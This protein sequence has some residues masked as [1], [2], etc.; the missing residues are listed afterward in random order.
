MTM[1][2]SYAM[3]KTGASYRQ[4]DYWITRG[5]VDLE[6]GTGKMGSGV[7][8]LFGKIDLLQITAMVILTETGVAVQTAAEFA[9]TIR[10]SKPVIISGEAEFLVGAIVNGRM[11]VGIQT[12]GGPTV[13]EDLPRIVLPLD[14]I[15]ARL[16][17]RLP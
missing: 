3:E 1:T 7:N 9:Q 8:K 6:S 10:L 2:V 15:Y 5:Y 14:S 17:G 4:I 16:E 12:A 11:L 13:F